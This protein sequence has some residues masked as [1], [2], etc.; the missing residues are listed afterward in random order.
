VRPAEPDGHPRRPIRRALLAG[1]VALVLVAAAAGTWLVLNSGSKKA[2]LDPQAAID[3]DRGYHLVV[4]DYRLPYSSPSGAPFSESSAEAI[5][6]FERRYPNVTVDLHLL[7]PSAGPTDLAAALTAG[8]PPDVYCSPFGP[9]AT[10]SDLQIPIGLYLDYETWAE[11]HP[12]AWQTV[13]TGGTVWSWPRYLLLWPWLGNV[14][15]LSL[16]GVDPA[17]ISTGGWTREQFALA[18]SGLAA[19]GGAGRSAFLAT[20]S[21]AVV[22]RDLLFSAGLAG[23]AVDAEDSAGADPDAAGFWRGPKPGEV[24]RWLSRLDQAKTLQPASPNATVI[25]SFVRGRSAVLAGPSPWATLFLLE[26]VER[27]AAWQFTLP[28]RDDRP[29]MVLLPPPHGSG[30]PSVAW[31]SAA[32]VTVFRQARYRGDDNTRLAVELARELTVGTRPWLRDQYL[33]VPA[34]YGELASWRVRCERSGPV[35]L[36][37]VRAFDQLARLPG[38]RLS[39][40]LTTLDY[41]PYVPELGPS[42]GTEAGAAPRKPSPAGLLQPGYLGPFLRDVVAPSAARLWSGEISPE[43]MAAELGAFWAPAPPEGGD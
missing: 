8:Y 38:G 34:A 35:G 20:N 21:P 40:V 26:P 37:A 3:P 30:E 18:A 39:S 33:C 11:Y 32:T 42:Q 16:A 28:D 29:A 15:L 12:V 6:R 14:D 4:W 23:D 1:L 41:G 19:A 22:V 17:A 13:K 5:R 24:L 25:D 7:D 10:G 43:D 27:P 36:F 2:G 31:V 9:P